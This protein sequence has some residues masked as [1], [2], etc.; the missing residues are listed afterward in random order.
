ME[1]DEVVKKRR[2]VRKFRSKKPDWRVIIDAV[3]SARKAPLAGNLASVKFILVDDVEVI[4]ELAEASQQDFIAQCSYVVVVVSDKVD[5]TRSY[6]ERG[7]RY[8]RQ[9]AGAAIEQ[10]LLKITDLGLASCW[11]GA[12][13]DEQV[14]R[15]LKIPEDVDVE[16]ILP[17]GY[18]YFKGKQK[19][20]PNLDRILYFNK[21]KHKFLKKKIEIEAH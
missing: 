7:E 18:E 19:K 17:I 6:Y 12:F 16:A 11:I 5:V 21:W 8:A 20:K 15:A 10:F 3:E 9:Q 2:S 1:F 14:K 13:V 4:A